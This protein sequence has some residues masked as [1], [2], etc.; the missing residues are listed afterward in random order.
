MNDRS[1]FGERVSRGSGNAFS[2][3]LVLV[4]VNLI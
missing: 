3:V 2:P 4:D 1:E